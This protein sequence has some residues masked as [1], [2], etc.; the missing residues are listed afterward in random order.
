MSA[1]MPTEPARTPDRGSGRGSDCLLLGDRGA[2]TSGLDGG[3]RFRLDRLQQ[4]DAQ[5]T[6]TVSVKANR[7]GD[8][9]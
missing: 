7:R 2:R 5:P 4:L 9:P 6:A 8:V 3:E 1:W